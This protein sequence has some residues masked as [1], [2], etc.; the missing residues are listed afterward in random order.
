MF[1]KV[2]ESAIPAGSFSL[3]H[4]FANAGHVAEASQP[5]PCK[6]KDPELRGPTRMCTDPADQL[7]LRKAHLVVSRSSQKL[8][9]NSV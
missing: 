4:S 6:Q 3:A 9:S 8:M 2:S 5:G 1:S 7:F